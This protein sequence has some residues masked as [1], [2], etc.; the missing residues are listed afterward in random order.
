MIKL[1]SSAEFLKEYMVLVDPLIELT[2][3]ENYELSELA[4]KTIISLESVLGEHL[5]R[6]FST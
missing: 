6:K 1:T 5:V 2:L 4:L 3:S